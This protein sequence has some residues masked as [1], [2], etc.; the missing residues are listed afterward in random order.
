MRLRHAHFVLIASKMALLVLETTAAKAGIVSAG[1]HGKR[2]MSDLTRKE[3]TVAPAARRHGARK[4][5]EPLTLRTT[6]AISTPTTTPI[7]PPIPERNENQAGAGLCFS[8]IGESSEQSCARAAPSGF[9][10]SFTSLRIERYGVSS[11]SGSALDELLDVLSVADCFD[12]VR[13]IFQ[14]V[15]DCFDDVRDTF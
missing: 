8:R 10:K 14:A 11:G 12:D 6:S 3:Q 7:A 1:R 15:T 13:D 9:V 5:S 2:R 4:A